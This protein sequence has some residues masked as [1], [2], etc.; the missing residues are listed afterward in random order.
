MGSVFSVILCEEQG[1]GCDG[2]VGWKGVRQKERRGGWG[3]THTVVLF[4]V[5][6]RAVGRVLPIDT[7]VVLS[8]FSRP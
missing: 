2:Q 4:S 6:D 5:A 7:R 1:E 8:G 3:G